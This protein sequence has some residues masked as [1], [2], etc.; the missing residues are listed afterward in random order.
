MKITAPILAL[1]AALGLSACGE[2][3]P[4]ENTAAALENAAEQSTPE[5]AAVLENQADQIRDQNV[6][7]PISEPGSPG[8][9]A[10]QEAGNAQAAAQAAPA[11]APS[12][13]AKPHAPGDPVPPPKVA[14]DGTGNHAG[15]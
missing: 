3:T 2:K 12:Q 14:A 4:A 5:A 6:T 15:H 8:Q 9:Q 1:T 13:G 10:L 7:A 11:A